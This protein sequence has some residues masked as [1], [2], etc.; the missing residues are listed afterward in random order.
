MALHSGGKPNL[1]AISSINWYPQS[2][3]F[4]FWRL[5]SKSLGL[6]DRT[7]NE[8]TKNGPDRTSRLGDGYELNDGVI[9]EVL[10]DESEDREGD[11]ERED[12]RNGLG[13]HLFLG[14]SLGTGIRGHTTNKR[15]NNIADHSF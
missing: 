7:K 4:G 2:G 6:H 8:E 11:E 10:A 15:L 14:R 12:G 13:H 9:P 3:Y 1:L 5:F